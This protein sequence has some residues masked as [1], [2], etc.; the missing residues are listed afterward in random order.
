MR[1]DT[2]PLTTP[3]D[4]ACYLTTNRQ[5]SFANWTVTE[6]EHLRHVDVDDTSDRHPSNEGRHRGTHREQQPR[7]TAGRIFYAPGKV[8]D[9]T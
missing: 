9:I 3:P 2:H 8:R 1:G 5:T 6:T 7:G 4:T